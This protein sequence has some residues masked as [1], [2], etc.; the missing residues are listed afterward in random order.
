MTALASE[1]GMQ[2]IWDALGVVQGL[3]TIVPSLG[4]YV[5]DEQEVI[6]EERR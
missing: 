2:K 4:V 5:D 1:I 6:N 3:K